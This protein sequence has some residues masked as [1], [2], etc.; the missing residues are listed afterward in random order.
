MPPTSS[1][2]VPELRSGQ[3]TL[4]FSQAEDGL[5]RAIYAVSNQPVFV[6]TS[7]CGGAFEFL[8]ENARPDELNGPVLH[9]AGRW[10]TAGQNGPW[11]GQARACHDLPGWF[12]LKA[13]FEVSEPLALEKAG[14]APA[15][16][17]RLAEPRRAEQTVRVSQPT[18]HNP[19]VPWL[20]SNDLPAAYLWD[21]PS[22]TETV[23]FP[24]LEECNWFQRKGLNRL[25]DYRCGLAEDGQTFGFLLRPDSTERPT[26]I[27]A[28]SYSLNFRVFVGPKAARPDE[29]HAVRTLVKRCADWLPGGPV[30][31]PPNGTSWLDFEKQGRDELMRQG[32]CWLEDGVRGYVAYVQEP[33]QL[34]RNG[35]P[36]DERIEAMASLDVLPPWLAMLRLQP[37]PA[38]EEHLLKV[39]DS[40]SH[41]YSPEHRLFVNQVDLHTGQPLVRHPNTQVGA[42][43]GDSWYFFEPLL[44]LGWC[45]HLTPPGATADKLRAIFLASCQRATEFI[46]QHNYRPAAFYNPLTLAPF[47]QP[48][49]ED[50]EDI[51]IEFWTGTAPSGSKPW[52]DWLNTSQNW[53]CL[54]LYAYI[55]LQAHSLSGEEAYREEAGK[56][57]D[58]LAGCPPDSLFWEPFEL[59]YAVAAAALTGRF[60][61]AADLAA[62]LLRMGYWHDETNLPGPARP[63]RGL[64]QA[65]VG[66]RY[67]AQKENGETLLPLLPWLHRV[68][69][70]NSPSNVQPSD[71]SNDQAIIKTVLKFFNLA[72]SSALA[73][74]SPLLDKAEIYPGRETTT[75]PHIPF[76]DLEMFEWC[77]A[78]HISRFQRMPEQGQASGA[79][80]REIYG[81]G[82]TT[83][84]ALLFEALA[85]TS[86]PTVMVL[87][88]DLFEWDA[89]NDFPGHPAQN[90]VLYNPGEA[91][92][93]AVKFKALQPDARYRLHYGDQDRIIAPDKTGFFILRNIELAKD[94]WLR[95]EILRQGE[96]FK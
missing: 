49:P 40:L 43:Y 79:L 53:A 90:F 93:I 58:A 1:T 10:Q 56:A 72:R 36:L 95:L 28:G 70:L 11:Q 83:W 85:E 57:L 67:P 87:N 80:G 6:T 76:E 45:A 65:W 20:R 42:A 7:F 35:G 86:D 88:L 26:V 47:N 62:N 59:S 52:L 18:E 14:Q 33:S 16:A 68:T 37:N 54:G 2:S 39:A 91:V 73:H 4:T 77:P 22:G 31:P 41:H 89:M 96:T 55:M 46:R 69:A 21:E 92:N 75:T 19:P 78:M 48:I 27:P 94:A 8:I 84:F 61:Q 71:Q 63:R 50:A 15:L 12:K 38:Q 60:A 25:A 34:A 64:F 51:T 9:F 23:V 82:E 81:A 17:L 44:R 13:V 5:Y 30:I 66:I 24:D 29:W 32:L 3:A 74:Y